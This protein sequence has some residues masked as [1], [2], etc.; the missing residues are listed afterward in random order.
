[1]NLAIVKSSPD[2]PTDVAR[3]L[4]E[5]AAWEDPCSAQALTRVSK[6]VRQ[7]IDPILYRTA[8]LR[9][10]T[11]LAQFHQSIT[12][13]NDSAFF[14]Q[15]VKLLRFG[16]LIY[17]NFDPIDS[18][19]KPPFERKMELIRNVLKAC[20]GVRR[21]AFWLQTDDGRVLDGFTGISS[22]H[23]LTHLSVLDV[24][25]DSYFGHAYIKFLPPSLT[26]LHLDN[27]SP[28]VHW[29]CIP[30]GIFTALPRLSHICLSGRIAT[31]FLFRD[32]LPSLVD[33]IAALPRTITTFVLLVDHSLG[34]PN[35]ILRPGTVA[36]NL[37]ALRAVSDRLVVI[38]RNS[39]YLGQIP[40]VHC[41]SHDHTIESDWGHGSGMD[42]WEF[43]DICLAKQSQR[44]QDQLTC[45]HRSSKRSIKNDAEDRMM[46][47]EAGIGTY[48]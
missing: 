31:V 17:A 11:Q 19:H 28:D 8:V 5:T 36:S 29:R 24:R 20:S 13:R 18:V 10:V 4:L 44:R 47:V 1:M 21:V 42:V 38:N 26:H 37:E 46:Y 6:I 35:T 14:A 41:F 22:S 16:N 34:S 33:S 32:F 23:H 2:F 25:R 9:T 3:S 15:S 7:W 39:S 45:R 30:W 48:A 40:H 12:L 43:A 27:N